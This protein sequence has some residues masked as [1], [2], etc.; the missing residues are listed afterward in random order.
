M[1]NICEN[2]IKIKDIEKSEEVLN[3]LKELISE[4][5]VD[6]IINEKILWVRVYGLK[7]NYDEIEK[8][9]VDIFNYAKA[10][11]AYKKAGQL[12]IMIGKYYIDFKKDSEAAKYLDEGVNIF[13]NLGVL[14]N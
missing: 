8:I 5:N 1:M 13:K 3:Q 4:D 2:Y 12:A 7:E 14:N 9:L 11:G 10:N 6:M